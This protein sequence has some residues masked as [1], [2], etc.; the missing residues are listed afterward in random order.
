LTDENGHAAGVEYI[1]PLGRRQIQP[2]RTVILGAYTFEN[3]RLMFL[4]RSATHPSGIGGRNAQLGRYFMTKMFAHVDGFFPNIIFNRHTGPAA[5]G[6][7]IDDFVSAEFDFVKHGFIGG[8]TLG[9]EQQFLPIQISREAL[10]QDVCAWGK[11]YRHH[12]KQWQ[13]FGVVRIQPDALPYSTNYLELDPFHRDKSGLGQPVLRITYDLRENERKLADWM[14]QKAEEILGI[15]GATKTWR[16]A[17]FT[18]VGS[19]HDFGGARMGNDPRTSVVNRD[20]EVHD[21]PGVYAFSGATFPSCVGINPT[22]TL[23]AICCRAA[24]QLVQK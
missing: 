7:V 5:Q 11:S 6:V 21:T 8:A 10:P 16:G 19:S 22:L 12:L 18:G 13:H 4:S 3:I 14:E 9:A 20:L 15:M 1:D 23:A 17:S 2:G 24:G